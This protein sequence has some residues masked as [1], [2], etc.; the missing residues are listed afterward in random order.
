LALEEVVLSWRAGGVSHTL[1]VDADGVPRLLSGG[2]A[3]EPRAAAPSRRRKRTG[4]EPAPDAEE[5]PPAAPVDPARARRGKPWTTD[6]E[7][8]IRAGFEAAEP[9]AALGRRIG[10]SAGAVTARLV[11]LGLL[12][13]EE[14]GL[15]YP[16]VARGGAAD[17]SVSEASPAS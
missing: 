6:E 3:E 4:E 10:R 1:T 15:R 13:A 14:A 12:S 17:A 8:Y 7:A 2:A 9:P 11:V 16:V 5:A